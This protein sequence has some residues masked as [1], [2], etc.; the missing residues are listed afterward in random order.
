M[1]FFKVR[2]LLKITT[3][4]RDE[5]TPISSDI[6]QTRATIIYEIIIRKIHLRPLHDLFYLVEK[7][8]K[9]YRVLQSFKILEYIALD[10]KI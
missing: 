3:I 7:V 6:D 8:D 5:N 9:K 2:I 10:M 1:R 4:H